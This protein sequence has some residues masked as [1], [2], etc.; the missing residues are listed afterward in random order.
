MRITRAPSVVKVDWRQFSEALLKAVGRAALTVSASVTG[1]AVVVV[2]DVLP[3]AAGLSTFELPGDGR[4]TITAATIAP[5]TT[6][7]P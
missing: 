1:P 6:R 4:R 7:A 2:E 5:M 3:A